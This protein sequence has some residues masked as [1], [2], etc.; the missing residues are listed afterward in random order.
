CA[1]LLLTLEGGEKERE[2][3]RE[4]KGERLHFKNCLTIQRKEDLAAILL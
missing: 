2:K 4:K 3:E 1:M